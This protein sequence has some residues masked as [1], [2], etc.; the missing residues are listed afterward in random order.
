MLEKGPKKFGSR[1]RHHSVIIFARWQHL[2]QS[3]SW[4]LHLEAQFWGRGGLRGSVM[5]PFKKAVVVSYRLSIMTIQFAIEC[6]QCS[7]QQRVGH[8]GRKGS[9]VVSQILT[10][11]GETWGCRMQNKSC[12][13]LLPFEHN[14]RKSQRDHG[15]V[16]LIS[17]N[18]M[19]AH[20]WKWKHT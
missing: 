14:T 3:C 16:T 15:T 7:N 13:Y 20:K 6:L 9:T 11:L 8:L 5:V 4:V 10:D 1:W 2:S 18:N 12:R 17:I 19:H